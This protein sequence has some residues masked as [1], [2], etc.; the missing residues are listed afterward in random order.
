MH[1]RKVLLVLAAA[2][3]IAACGDDDPAAPRT[4][5]YVATLNS[6]NEIA[7]ASAPAFPSSATGTATITVQGN[8]V[9]WTVVTTGFGAGT[10]GP[11]GA[12][13][14]PAHIHF[15]GPTVNGGIMVDLSAAINGS[16][17]GTRTVVDSVLTH[18]RAGNT[19]ANVHT[20][21]RA[22]GEIRGQLVRTQ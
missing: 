5:T 15:G 16:S 14:P 1:E 13:A 3:A 17:T 22:A 11:G 21:N 12:A 8:T 19:Y 18:L 10:T 4:E 2:V 6:A 9:N 7:T 20:S